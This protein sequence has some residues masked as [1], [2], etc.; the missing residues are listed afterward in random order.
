MTTNPSAARVSR[1][2]TAQL[3][4]TASVGYFGLRLA[5]KGLLL[6][7]EPCSLRYAYTAVPC[8]LAPFAEPFEA[9]CIAFACAILRS[10]SFIYLSPI[11]SIG[12]SCL[13]QA[14]IL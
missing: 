11:V 1:I 13:S 3:V 8:A 4:Q 2:L 12:Y 9:T 10:T 5:S 6:S 7:I 14:K